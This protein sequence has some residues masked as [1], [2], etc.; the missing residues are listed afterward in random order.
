MAKKFVALMLALM[1]ALNFSSIGLAKTPEEK[2]AAK[3]AKLQKKRE[4]QLLKVQRK[5]NIKKITA[6]AIDIVV[7]VLDKA[8]RAEKKSQ[9]ARRRMA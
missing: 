6:W 8:T 2:A 4:K 7:C 3:D 1:L 5:D 9:S